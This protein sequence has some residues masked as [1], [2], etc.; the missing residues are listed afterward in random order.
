MGENSQ[1]LGKYS[2]KGIHSKTKKLVQFQLPRKWN[3]GVG[4]LTRWSEEPEA[5]VQLR[6][7]PQKGLVAQMVERGA[8]SSCVSG[9]SP[10]QPTKW[11]NTQVG[12]GVR[13]ESV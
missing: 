12:E 4:G 7:V 2:V 9:S 3:Y 10:F 5:P 13:L 6:L 8:V 11:R 1:W